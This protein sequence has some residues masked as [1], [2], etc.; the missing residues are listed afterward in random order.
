MKKIS[1]IGLGKLG[2]S[3]LV[4]VASRGF[5]II[6][7]DNNLDFVE[8]LS[9]GEANVY[10]PQLQGFLKKYIRNIKV[11]SD[12]ETTIK[13]SEI[14]FVIVPTPS[15]KN[16]GF[17]TKYVEIVCEKVGEQLKNKKGYHLVVIVS[18]V[19]PLSMSRAIK[20]T[21]EKHSGKKCGVGFGLCYNPEFIA[22]GSVIKNLLNPDV[23]LIGES[24]EVAGDKLTKFYKKFCL[25]NPPISRM[26]F[27]NAELTK[28]SLNSYVTMKISFSNYLAEICENIP[29]G[30]VDV[31]TSTLGNDK[32]IGSKYLKGALGYGGPCF[33]RDNKALAS[34]TK[35]CGLDAS[36]PYTTDLINNR[37][38]ERILKK[39][40]KIGLR[41]GDRI[42]I[43]GLSYKPETNVIEKSQSVEIAKELASK[44]RVYVYDPAS[45][46]SAKSELKDRVMYAEDVGSAV[47]KSDLIII[48]TPWEIIKTELLN[49]LKRLGNKKIIILDI[50]RIYSEEEKKKFSKFVEYVC[51]G[52]NASNL[53]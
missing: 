48:A 41:K 24:D 14:T 36:I 44:Y 32:R 46:E 52:V 3:F 10:E 49:S 37:Q 28:I 30:N 15:D 34:F 39:V 4:A 43:L 26:S 11:T 18:T 12:Y 5:K 23:V 40:N 16:G 8:K 2:S 19:L 21:L 53:V 27:E 51:L 33:P 38:I 42:A 35:K 13:N 50:W 22:L 45:L 47:N 9:N 25:N 17:S 7:L 1:V 20:P 31:V 6:G 29:G